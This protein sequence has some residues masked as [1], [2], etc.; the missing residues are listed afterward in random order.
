[1]I[2]I[3]TNYYMLLNTDIGKQIH[4]IIRNTNN[5]KQQIHEQ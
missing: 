4:K 5:G 3:T 1:M 2:F